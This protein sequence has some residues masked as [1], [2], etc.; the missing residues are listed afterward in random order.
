[1]PS[2]A[3]KLRTGE[4]KRRRSQHAAL[5]APAN[6]ASV[7]TTAA[8]AVSRLTALLCFIRLILT[9]LV[10]ALVAAPRK[11]GYLPLKPGP[12]TAAD[13]LAGAR[14]RPEVAGRA[15]A[16]RPTVGGMA[17]PRVHHKLAFEYL[18]RAL[19]LDEDGAADKQELTSQLY[20]HGIEELERGLALT[21]EGEDEASER[22]RKLQQKMSAN[23]LLARERLQTLEHEISTVS[24][25][26]RSYNALAENR[27]N[28]DGSKQKSR[29]GHAGDFRSSS[30]PREH[31]IDE[32]RSSSASSRGTSASD[33]S[34]ARS[35]QSATER[36]TRRPA[37]AQ[38]GPKAPPAAPY[39]NWARP[40][41]PAT[42]RRQPLACPPVSIVGNRNVDE[43]LA[44]IILGEIVDR[45]LSVKFSD[46]GGLQAAKQALQEMVILPALRP[47]LFTGLRAPAKGLLLF[48]PPGNGKT[49]LAKA[50]A[51]ECH[52]TFFNISAASLTSKYLGEGE[53][54]VR[55]L[56]TKAR[57]MQPSIVFIDEVD[58][59]LSSR[60]DSEHEASRRLKTEFL[61]EFDGVASVSESG[62]L[63]RVLVMAATNRPQ[64]LDEAALRR[65]AKRIYVGLPAQKTRADMLHKLLSSLPAAASCRIAD[66]EL[67][68][69]A[70]RTEGYSGSDLANLARDAALAP[71][72][73]L[74]AEAVRRVDPASVRP[75]TAADFEASLQHVRP[76]LTA[77]A[78]DAY[79][80][81]SRTLGDSAGPS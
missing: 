52:S 5:G 42:R 37:T 49:M 54:L 51:S 66:R 63:C 74:S 46:I 29:A 15:H 48:G 13:S 31:A 22:T 33:A 76:S 9:Q 32:R 11:L 58:S 24:D 19:E 69:I 64:D 41:A 71:I 79:E 26:A 18:S 36:P 55:A 10:L 8:A 81:W 78:L 34:P 16:N 59:L 47:E 23:L 43:R 30:C 61:V 62:G 80:R 39:Q 72:R 3:S 28:F 6:T 65:F 1:M 57:E 38:A 60:R 17:H 35:K 73:E 21:V 14:G 12:L 50:V 7:D 56:F 44:G 27:R 67:L 40:S 2:G 75:V 53:K 20:K 45:N 77:D 68:D 4:S 25:R 70:R